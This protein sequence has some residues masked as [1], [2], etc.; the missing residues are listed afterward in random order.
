MP[1]RPWLPG[2]RLGP[3]AAALRDEARAFYREVMA[4]DRVEGHRDRSDLTGW[5]EDF[6]REVLARAG[7]EGLLGVSL[8][9]EFGGAGRPRSHQAIVTF[10][11][12]YHDAPLIDTAAALV[13]PSVVAF[14]TAAQR[15]SS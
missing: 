4:P 15:R 13:A 12:A 5:D 2:L 10:E 1:V 11:A 3:E 8:P 7:A 9:V 6:E 14:G